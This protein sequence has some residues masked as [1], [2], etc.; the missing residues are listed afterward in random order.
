MTL[1]GSLVGEWFRWIPGI[2]SVSVW[3]LAWLNSPRDCWRT[4][5]QSHRISGLFN[6]LSAIVFN[7]GKWSHRMIARMTTAER[8]RRNL[9]GVWSAGWGT[10]SLWRL[11]WCV[12]GRWPREN[13][14]MGECARIS[15]VWKGST[16]RCAGRAIWDVFQHLEIFLCK[17]KKNNKLV[18]CI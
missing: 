3:G 13:G 4:I 18:Y 6:I 11:P 5:S 12:W 15:A 17:E 16:E 8:R 7:C 9:W 10:A 2:G 14:I 1:Q